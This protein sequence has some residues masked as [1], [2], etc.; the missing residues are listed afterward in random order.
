MRVITDFE[1]AVLEFGSPKFVTGAG[2]IPFPVK[3]EELFGRPI[4]R[5]NP[6]AKE[7]AVER[8]TLDLSDCLVVGGA[9][10]IYCHP[11]RCIIR[12]EH[13]DWHAG[14]SHFSE[15]NLERIKL[16]TLESVYKRAPKIDGCGLLL[17][18]T[19]VN[20]YFHFLSEGIGKIFIAEMNG[21]LTQVDFIVVT[22]A[23]IPFIKYWCNRLV[24]RAKLF[25]LGQRAVAFERLVVPSYSQQCGA[26]SFDL[27]RFLRDRV[28][29]IRPLPL[30]NRLFISRTGTRVPD[31]QSALAVDLAKCGFK[32]LA[33][34]LLAIEDQIRYFKTATVLV[35]PHGAGMV[36]SLFSEL[37]ET[38]IFELMSEDYPNDC[39][40]RLAYVCGLRHAYWNISR[41]GDGIRE[42]VQK[43]SAVIE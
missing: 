12:L 30:N 2:R 14:S 36:N 1:E 20:T 10:S 29:D 39:Y 40:L 4:Q 18:G 31:F 27:V 34:E 28:K 41:G 5:L 6:A 43:I 37:A 21:L 22:G 24:P 42:F 9:H 23:E 11:F 8:F 15:K 38:K 16:E 35:G 26:F 19:W 7:T 25:S 32:E 3:G 17:E 33:L 13:L